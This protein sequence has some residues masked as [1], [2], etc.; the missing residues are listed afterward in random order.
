[1]CVMHVSQTLVED[2]MSFWGL[3]MTQ[4]PDCFLSR[5]DQRRFALWQLSVWMYPLL[6]NVKRLVGLIELNHRFVCAGFNSITIC[7]CI[8]WKYFCSMLCFSNCR[9]RPYT[10]P[11]PST[12]Y[13]L[14]IEEGRNWLPDIVNFSSFTYCL[15]SNEFRLYISLHGLH[16]PPVC[17]WYFNEGVL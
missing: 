11:R 9:S 6:S 2:Q 12:G 15:Q 13:H 1:M 16:R 14:W 10:K 17:N 8:Q 3:N 4:S 7:V 5:F